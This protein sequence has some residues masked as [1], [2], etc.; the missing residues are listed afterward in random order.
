[1]ILEP[2]RRNSVSV[3]QIGGIASAA[4]PLGITAMNATIGN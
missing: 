2:S 3:Q 1:M 4:F